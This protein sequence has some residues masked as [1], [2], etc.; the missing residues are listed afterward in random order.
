MLEHVDIV[1]SFAVVMLLLSLVVTTLV[2]IVVAASWQRY[3]VLKWG[4]ARLI[5]QAA[6]GLEAEDAATIAEAVLCHPTVSNG[7][8]CTTAIRKEELIRLLGDLAAGK[9]ESKRGTLSRDANDALAGVIK[10][11]TS[12][13]F[14]SAAGNLKQEL[15]KVFPAEAA[16]MGQVVDQT[17]TDTRKIVDDVGAWFDT[18]MDRT[19]DQ[20]LLRT[21]LITAILA[22]VLAF[23]FH[24]DSLNILRQLESNPDVRTKLVQ[25]ADATLRRAEDV[26]AL[27]AGRTA[28]ASA[29]IRAACEDPNKPSIRVLAGSVPPDLITRN[30][31]IAWVRSAVRDPNDCNTLLVAYEKRFDEKTRTWLQDLR[32]SAVAI[33]ADLDQSTLAILPKPFPAQWPNFFSDYW[34]LHF[35]GTLMTAAFLSLGAPFWYNVLKQ[36]SSLRP[37]IAQK[38][39]P[40]P[41]TET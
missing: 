30:D 32:Q 10:V 21:R 6:P 27:S 39:E 3:R 22:V 8:T 38:V 28:M 37:A 12:K 14:L 41:A 11:G 5:K 33:K 35:W 1:L 15:A 9:P 13:E 2:Q 17:L 20:F 4:I 34:G 40:K 23:V 18:V 19:T 16:R 26:L 24:I 29:A 25:S 7:K 31:G 36:L